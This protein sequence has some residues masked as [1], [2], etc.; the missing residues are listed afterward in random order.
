MSSIAMHILVYLHSLNTQSRIL[1]SVTEKYTRHANDLDKTFPI[2]LWERKG[3]VMFGVSK[4][5][6]LI[7]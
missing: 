7:R 3:D 6:S 5:I 1:R 2:L 4:H